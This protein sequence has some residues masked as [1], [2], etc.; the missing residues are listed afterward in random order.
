MDVTLISMTIV[1]V[2]LAW[3]GSFEWRLRNMSNRLN[4]MAT[5]EE[6]EKL[7]DLKQEVL[8]VIQTETRK[9]I[10]VVDAKLDKLID[11]LSK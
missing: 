3:L 1:P 5:K 10:Q 7:I 11:T 2:I 4:N 6:I 9:D 8:Q